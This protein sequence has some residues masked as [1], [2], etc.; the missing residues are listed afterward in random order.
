MLSGRPRGKPV[1]VGAGAVR[2]TVAAVSDGAPSGSIL[3]RCNPCTV[4]AT[5]NAACARLALLHNVMHI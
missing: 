2:G 4:A 5:V 3:G 1:N